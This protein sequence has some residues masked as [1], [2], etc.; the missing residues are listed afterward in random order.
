MDKKPDFDQYKREKVASSRDKPQAG[1]AWDEHGRMANSNVKNAHYFWDAKF[2][3]KE[4]AMRH[5]EKAKKHAADYDEL[6]KSE[7]P[8]GY[9]KKTNEE[10]KQIY[11]IS[12]KLALN[13]AKGAEK[14]MDNAMV[15]GSE[16][17]ETFMKRSKGH[18]LAL[19]KIN[20]GYKRLKAKVGTSDANA[21]DDAYDKAVKEDVDSARAAQQKAKDYTEMGHDAGRIGDEKAM[22]RHFANAALEKLKIKAAMRKKEVSEEV[23]DETEFKRADLE[24]ASAALDKARDSNKRKNLDPDLKKRAENWHRQNFLTKQ[25]TYMRSRVASQAQPRNEEIEVTSEARDDI[26]FHKDALENLSGTISRLKKG[27]RPIPDDLLRQLDKHKQAVVRLRSG[28]SRFAEDADPT[29]MQSDKRDI[30]TSTR[31]SP[32]GRVE[33]FKRHKP[34]KQIKI[35]ESNDMIEEK[36]NRLYENLSDENKE[37][38]MEKLET[39]EGIMQLFQFAEE[40]G[41]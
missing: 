11:E 25:L 2:P 38:F 20:Q 14:S 9:H 39:E 4:R 36:L 26:F 22:R 8:K 33:L 6:M 17:H 1:S 41:F 37:R 34:R 15:K 31:I 10:V 40:Q 18:T 32:T 24:R 23:L 16:G 19:D 28:K 30:I 35:G 13:Y 3:D 7:W 21:K 27:G 12:D 5:A 29:T